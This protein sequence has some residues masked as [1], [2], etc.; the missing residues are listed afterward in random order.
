MKDTYSIGLDAHKESIA[1][2]YALGG[3]RSK[4][5]YHGGCGG[6]LPAIAAAL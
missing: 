1:I 2:A 4:A 3:S 6:S 5:V